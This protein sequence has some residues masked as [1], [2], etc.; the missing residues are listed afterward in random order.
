MEA[1]YISA[2]SSRNENQY[3]LGKPY[4]F[5]FLNFSY[6][7]A[8]CKAKKLYIHKAIMTSDLNS[9]FIK[10]SSGLPLL[11]YPFYNGLFNALMCRRFESIAFVKVSNKSEYS[12]H[13][14]YEIRLPKKRTNSP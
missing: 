3:T 9:V 4:I 12:M 11:C 2:V 14:T 6:L 5:Y 7:M 8:N 10:A 13:R 1:V